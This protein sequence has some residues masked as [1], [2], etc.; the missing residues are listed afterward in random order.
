MRLSDLKVPLSFAGIKLLLH[1]ATNT[2][3]GFHRDELLYLALG[4]HLDWGYW[5]NPPFIGFVSFVNQSLFGGSLFATRLVPALFGA[6]LLF[7]T[8]LIAKDLGGKKFAQILTGLAMMGSIA[9][10]RSSHMFMPVIIDVFFWTLSAWVVIRYLKSNENKWLLWL[11]VA[12]GIGF[13]NKY[14]VFFLLLALGIA[15]LLTPERK[16]FLKKHTWMGLG[17]ALAIVLPNLLWQWQYNFPVIY[18]FSILAET[19][20]TAVNPLIFLLD[21]FLMHFW[22][23]LVWIPGLIFL[24]GNR[25]MKQFRVIGWTFVITLLIFLAL[26]GKNY[27]TLG[28]YPMLMAAGGVFWEKRLAAVWKRWALAGFVLAANL[29]L[30]PTG[31]PVLSMKQS[32]A[33]FDFMVHK[34]GITSATRWERG[35]VEPLPQDYADM[36]GWQEIAALVDQAAAQVQDPA[37]LFLYCENYGQAGAVQRFSTFP[38]LPPPVSFAD[39]YR[40]WAPDTLPSIART[41]IYVNDEVGEDVQALFTRIDLMGEVTNPNARER[42]TKIY[43]CREPKTGFDVF[44]KERAAMV[45]AYFLR[46]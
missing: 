36:L 13:M 8:C 45:K 6:G 22:G 43:L 18:H 46:K 29:P 24:L 23:F 17:I 33:Y 34:L 42:G 16:V 7:F 4:K 2:H 28:A 20:L 40:L 9:Y 3:Y 30:L 11:G 44:W 21:Q 27:Y 10:L 5:S 19:Q 35:N 31:L 38:G 15:F 37:T 12:I 14:S 1:L 41:M 32:L 39:S 25:A 26:S